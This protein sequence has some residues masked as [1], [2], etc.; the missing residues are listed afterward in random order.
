MEATRHLRSAP[1]LLLSVIAWIDG[2]TPLFRRFIISA[3]SLASAPA[4]SIVRICA[5][6]TFAA[7]RLQARAAWMNC[8]VTCSVEGPCVHWMVPTC[9]KSPAVMSWMTSVSCACEI[10]ET[11]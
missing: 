5:M 2:N 4:K 3:I 7:R 11:A 6:R 8:G 10:S 9:G 1:V